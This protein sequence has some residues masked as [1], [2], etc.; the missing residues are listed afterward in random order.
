[1]DCRYLGDVGRHMQ[2]PRGAQQLVCQRNA[3]G[4]SIGTTDSRDCQWLLW[5]LI[6]EYCRLHY[7][8]DTEALLEAVE[9]VSLP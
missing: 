5:P 7:C 4:M 9:Y 8:E 3:L 1:M 2:N 6:H